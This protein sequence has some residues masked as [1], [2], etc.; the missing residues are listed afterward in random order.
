[1]SGKPEPGFDA[2]GNFC[3][4][5]CGGKRF[6]VLLR[7]DEDRVPVRDR[8]CCHSLA[9]GKPSSEFHVAGVPL[10]GWSAKIE[11]ER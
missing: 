11:G 5:K 1:M 4:P 10:C 7:L 8:V 9:N 3:C 6:G 2:D